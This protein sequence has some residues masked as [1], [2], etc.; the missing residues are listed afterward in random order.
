MFLICKLWECTHLI[1]T[2]LNIGSY[3]PFYSLQFL[4]IPSICTLN[5]H[6][7]CFFSTFFAKK[8]FVKKLLVVKFQHSIWF[9]LRRRI[10]PKVCSMIVF[11]LS[12]NMAEHLLDI[13]SKVRCQLKLYAKFIVL[14]WYILCKTAFYLLVNNCSLIVHKIHAKLVTNLFWINLSYIAENKFFLTSFVVFVKTYWKISINLFLDTICEK[15]LDSHFL[16]HKYEAFKAF[17]SYAPRAYK[18]ARK[19]VIL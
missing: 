6:K 1:Y 13:F 17:A 16:D 14:I 2:V 15:K 12:L 19:L 3:Y 11:C 4:A 10:R 9:S 18:I 7:S 8:I 5:S